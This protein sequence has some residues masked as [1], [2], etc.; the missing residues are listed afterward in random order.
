MASDFRRLR[1][2]TNLMNQ[3]LQFEALG[4]WENIN[5]FSERIQAV[6]AE[7]IQRVAKKYFHSDNR[8]VAIYYPQDQRPAAPAAAAPSAK[9]EAANEAP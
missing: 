7:D 1:S 3:L 6:T 2:K 9:Q 4:S 5:R 8:N